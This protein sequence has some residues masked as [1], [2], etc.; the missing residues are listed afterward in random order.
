MAAASARSSSSPTPPTAETPVTTGRPAVRVPVLSKR[1]ASTVRICSSAIRSLTSTP[2]FAARSVAIET[3][4]GIARPRA[5]GQAMTRTVIT[6]IHAC[7]GVPK[8]NHAT[9]ARA[10]AP[11]ANQNSQPAALSASRCA[12][13]EEAC[14][15]AT[16]RW[17]PARAVS[18]PTAEMR[19]RRAL[20]VATV[21]ATTWSPTSRRTGL[22]SPVII[23]SSTSA[24]PST[25]SPSAG[26]RPPGRTT[27]TSPSCRSAGATLVTRSPS[28]R[29]ASSGRRAA[30]ES[31]AEDVCASERI[32]IQ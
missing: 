2:P 9:S 24:P 18:S 31:S 23:D 1:T 22:D 12:R 30:R 3:T 10:A 26:M 29:S 20:S 28:T 17:M 7:S 5:W 6:R 32:S 27:T 19:T 4:S 25:I 16:S 11:S 13:L 14:A 15:S 21:P 8:S